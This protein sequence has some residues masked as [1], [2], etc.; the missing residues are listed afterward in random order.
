MVVPPLVDNL[1][2]D[3]LRTVYLSSVAVTGV[4][5]TWSCRADG[6]RS[7]RGAAAASVPRRGLH[8]HELPDVPVQVLETAAVHGALLQGRLPRLPACRDRLRHRLV[9]VLPALGRQAGENL[10]GR[11]GV[12]DLA[13]DEV[14]EA[15]LGEQH[16]EDVLIDD[17]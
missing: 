2:T 7:R 8:V 5:P 12:A 3:Y 15:L 9:D 16:D 11:R 10:G 17:H 13:V 6:G 4:A 1:R 14:L